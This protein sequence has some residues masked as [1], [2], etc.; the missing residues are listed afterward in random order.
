M[1]DDTKVIEL[2]PCGYRAPCKVNNCK[3]KATTT[4]RS[5]RL[6][7]VRN[8][9]MSCAPCMPSRLRSESGVGGQEIVRRG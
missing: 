3:A 2:W 4:A 5:V 6:A 8:A 9:N 7:A 1:P